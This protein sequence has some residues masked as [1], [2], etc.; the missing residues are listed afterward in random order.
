MKK[1][2]VRLKKMIN[3]ISESINKW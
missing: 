3:L 1:H 2:V